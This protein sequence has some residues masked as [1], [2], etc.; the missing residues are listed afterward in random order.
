MARNLPVLLS[1]L[2]QNRATMIL[3]ADAIQAGQLPVSKRLRDD[4]ACEYLTAPSFENMIDREKVVAYSA[5]VRWVN[6][7]IA[8]C[9]FSGRGDEELR[10][11]HQ[12]IVDASSATLMLGDEIETMI[13]GLLEG[14]APLIRP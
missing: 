5:S 1:E 7:C 2:T 14:L 11:I 10:A 4:C 9:A 3:L 8:S 13:R 6:E 12:Q